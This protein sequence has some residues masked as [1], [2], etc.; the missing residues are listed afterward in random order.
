[1]ENNSTLDLLTLHVY[2]ETTE[3]QVDFLAKKLATDFT[4]QEELME[5]LR[6]K[7][8]LNKKMMSPSQTSVRIIMEYS[9][10]TERLST[11]SCEE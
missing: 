10:K 7:K 1:M 8:A 5:L 6:A 3:S 4:V 11:A 2:Q 9:H